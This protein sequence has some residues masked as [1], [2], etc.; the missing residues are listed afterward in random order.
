MTVAVRVNS[1]PKATVAAERAE[2]I[3]VGTGATVTVVAPLATSRIRS[4]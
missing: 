1:W 2:V 4:L 3:D